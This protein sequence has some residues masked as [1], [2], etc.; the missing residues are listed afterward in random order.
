[1]SG[2]DTNIIWAT[3]YMDSLLYEEAAL[4]YGATLLNGE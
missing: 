1:M 4:L 2:T 3:N